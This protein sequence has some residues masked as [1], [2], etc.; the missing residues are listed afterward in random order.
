MGVLKRLIQPV[1]AHWIALADQLQMTSLVPTIQST[2]ANTSPP[3]L[4]RDL[5]YRWLTKGHPTLDELCKAL[6]EDDEIIGGAGVAKTLRCHYQPGDTPFLSA[7][8]NYIQHPYSYIDATPTISNLYKAT[9]SY[10]QFPC[11]QKANKQENKEFSPKQD[12]FLFFKKTFY[13]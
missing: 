7:H 6:R 3:A 2:P 8:G 11:S 1:A 9:L 12:V 5:L 4:L 10:T 13:L